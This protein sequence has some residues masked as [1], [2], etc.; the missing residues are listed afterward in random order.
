MRRGHLRLTFLASLS[1]AF[2]AGTA[3]AD[4]CGPAEGIDFVLPVDGSA[5][6]ARSA[7]V[8]VRF[9]LAVTTIEAP[10]LWV[11][12]GGEEAVGGL[13]WD[14]IEATFVPDDLW[15]ASSTVTAGVSR[16]GRDDFVWEFEAAD[17]GEDAVAPV[18]G[19]DLDASATYLG[20]G[21][22][23]DPCGPVDLERY[24]VR[25]ELAAA[26][27]SSGRENLEYVAFQTAGP[28]VTE[29]VER[30]RAV[31]EEGASE[32]RLDFYLAADDVSG[33]ACFRAL[34]IDVTGP[35][36]GT[37]EEACADLREGPFFRSICAT[38][39]GGA[40]PGV[41]ALIVIAAAALLR[42]H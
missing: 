7:R 23:D 17:W 21:P 1:C 10:E 37:T 36:S 41:A 28:G 24:R 13:S 25:L 29:P 15:P 31:D 18:L 2:A 5:G 3:R 22:E 39:P 4:T 20:G 42:R 9:P 30:S 33:E 32:V 26:Q 16:S 19:T 11:V 27:G 12:A 14:G 35:P 8:V 38:A 6:V 40:R 34:A